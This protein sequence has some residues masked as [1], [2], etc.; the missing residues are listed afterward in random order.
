MIRSS[1]TPSV[2]LSVL[3]S[4]LLS[5]AGPVGAQGTPIG[6]EET[7]ALAPDRA[8]ALAELV[9]GSPEHF[10]YSCLH[11]QNSG[12]LESVDG[13]LR[14]WRERH[15]S[16]DP[17]QDRIELRQTLLRAS[18]DPQA[19]YRDLVRRLGLRFDQRPALADAVRDLPTRLDP[20]ELGDEVWL[21]DALAR[22]PGSLRGL[23]DGAL[24]RMAAR[25][26][27]GG[28]LRELL[29][30]LQ[31][32]DVPGLAR[33]V[34]R[35]LGLG[36]SRGFGAFPI[37]GRLL[38]AQLEECLSQRPELLADSN[39][40]R[41]Y[42]VRLAPGA[43]DDLR[44]PAVRL[45][46]LERL[47]RFAG[48]LPAAFDGLRAHVLHHRLD[49]DLDLDRLDAERLLAYLRV[50]RQPAYIDPVLRR[51][52][53]A[54]TLSEGWETGLPSIATDEPLVREY[55]GRL[56][57]RLDSFQRFVGVLR[58][59][60]V[61]R[62][63][64]EAKILSGA[65]DPERWFALLEDPRV[66]EELKQRVDL[67]L[68][69][70]LA[71]T[72]GP[73]QPVR[74]DV[75]VKN[76]ETLLVKVFEIDAA[77]FYLA[78]GTAPRLRELDA[79]LDLDGL[80]AHEER[81]YRY[82]ESPMR[83]VRRTFDFPALSEPGIYVVEWIGNGIASRAVIRKG[84]LRMTE[85]VGAAGHVLR[86]VDDRG[87]P[88]E[89]ASV[90]YAGR[91]YMPDER[92]EIAIPFSTDPGL[93]HLV[94]RR[95]NLAVLEEFEHLAEA[96]A[97]EAPA[98][99]EREALL[100]GER[101]TL[102]VRPRLQVA[103]RPISL[104]LLEGARLELRATDLD[105]VVAASTVRD[106]EL[107]NGVEFVHEFSVP[108]R[109]VSFSVQL[110]GRVR[111]LSE[112][113]DVELASNAVQVPLNGIDA[114]DERWTPLL[115][116]AAEGYWLEVRGKNGELGASRVVQVT[117]QHRDYTNART[118]QL[119]SDARGR[120]ELGS[121]EN[122][123]RLEVGGIGSQPSAWW[124][125]PPMPGGR[126]RELHALEG[127]AIR[128]PWD[129]AN[130]FSLFELRGGQYAFERSERGASWG[131][132]YLSLTD[133]AAGDYRLE[134]HGIGRVYDL[135]VT[136]GQRVSG[137]A[138]GAVRRLELSRPLELTIRDASVRG[139]ELVVQL[140]G[141]GPDARVHVSALRYVPDVDGHRRLSLDR[142]RNLAWGALHA[143]ENQYESG[144][145]ISDEYRY[146]L[147]RRFAQRFP[148]NLLA[149]AG[150]LLNPWAIDESTSDTSAG[151]GG[152]GG[153]FGGRRS[154]RSGGGVGAPA[155]DGAGAPSAR[156]GFANLDFLGEPALLFANLRPDEQGFVRLPL[157]RL[158]DRHLLQV[159]AVDGQATVSR[160]V[161]RPAVAPRLRDRRLA[162]SL[163]PRAHLVEDRRIEFLDAGASVTFTDATNAGVE[164]Y[165]DLGDVYRYFR[166]H[167]GSPELERFEFLV[168]WPALSQEEKL[169]RYSEFA[170]HELHVF[171][172]RKD[173]E[174]FERVVRPYLAHKAHKTFL[175]HWLL[176]ENLGGYLEPW[177]FAELNTFERILLLRE[178][179]GGPA[180]HVRELVELLPPE[181]FALR[182]YFDRLLA[183]R[184]LDADRT[185]LGVLL[186]E[187]ARAQE[188]AKVALVQVAPAPGAPPAAIAG[189]AR[190]ELGDAPLE[191]ALEEQAEL[192]KVLKDQ[193]YASNEEL[194]ADLE[195]R[196]AQEPFFQDL[197]DT[198]ELA[199]RHY[200]RVLLSA[201]D[202]GLVTPTPFW[203]D[204]AES[205][206]DGPF[207]S[208]RFPL[209]ARNLPEML[210]ALALLDLP[211]AAGEHT[212]EASPEG[213]VFTAGSRLFL[214]W[215]GMTRVEAAPDAR[216]I[217]VG[218]DFFR[219][220]DPFV[221]EQG[222]QRDKF[223]SG[224]FLVGVPYGCRVVV[225]NPTSTPVDVEVLLQIPAGA[226]PL[227]RGFVTRGRSVS[228]PGY[229]SASIEYGFY[230]PAAGTFR[231]Y[232]AHVGEDGALLA[233]AA[234]SE[235]Q[236]LAAPK[237]LDRT[238]WEHLSQAADL[239]TVLEHLEREN[240]ARLDLSRLAWRMRDRA[241]YGRILALLR[242]HMVFDPT[243]WSF[244]LHHGDPRTAR[245]FLERR[246]DLVAAAGPWLR[247]ELL[248]IEPVERRIYEHL[249][250]DPLVNARAHRFGPERRIYNDS[251]ARQYGRFLEVLAHKPAL[252]DLDRMALVH[253][254]LLQERI[255]EALEHFALIDPARIEARL[256]YDYLT[257]YLAFY[258]PEPGSARAIAAAHAEHPVPRW[259]A[260][261]GAVLAQLDEAEGR[262][263][264]GAGDPESRDERQGALA[265]AVPVLEL[266][267]EARRVTL[268]YANLGQAEIR[269]R[270]MN[271]E[272]LFSTSPFLQGGSGA[273]AAVQPHRVD[274]VELPK[275]RDTLV[276]D[277]PA[278]F[279]SANVL[280]EVRG[281]GLVRTQAYYAHDLRVEA[282]E[283]YGQLSVRRASDG[284][285]LPAT[286]VKVYAR[287]ADGR[288]RF[289]KDGYTDLRGRFDYVSVSGI[290]AAPSARFAV[291]VLSE[292]SGA[293]VR[294]LDPPRR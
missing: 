62:I 3:V 198:R 118:F 177:A 130:A 138:W 209:A 29:G 31:H 256:Q 287:L 179:E 257:A 63:F 133:L 59:D 220:D 234:P 248:T 24:P 111:S 98:H 154:L 168:R 25:D 285:P 144:R 190:Q 152:F 193:G 90:L 42:L 18:Q 123:S 254:L 136:R 52:Q 76:V 293:L 147:E 224:E 45:A 21:R 153:R 16:S 156:P 165:D 148:G 74:L 7:F 199:E 15:G 233:F 218:Q 37:H 277:L 126:P 106:L 8:R 212:S 172:R 134:L 100:A 201:M 188:H 4:L 175:D 122:I 73:G 71:R 265:A 278:E 163:D 161:L 239:E 135:R 132:S 99:V 129:G 104:A 191:D 35:E 185:Q 39:F 50:A 184:A 229:G 141:A 87:E 97:L 238:S 101:A 110:A 94:L 146:I 115:A 14:A 58:R 54:V 245:E 89:G 222:R 267:V 232:P 269:Y 65:P 292:E 112:S 67:R 109:S 178:L 30:R 210:L 271:I 243:L 263:P 282:R 166:T 20:A 13:L 173:P 6:F 164:V 57:E 215:R 93:R 205:A 56:F 171:L 9:P 121:L 78:Q 244:G 61:Q 275:D 279:A 125:A 167:G 91:E 81:T 253:Y 196:Q 288:I 294:E 26:L 158:G 2:R 82:E 44:D 107:R 70:G 281:G 272:L 12:E 155:R 223:V 36:G 186:E 151:E 235:L 105:G 200:W 17:R 260:R 174:F 159:V 182:T 170:G 214:A 250:Y 40:V 194:G 283:A 85:R 38:L 280:V 139:E 75:D 137:Q 84:T 251:F 127:E 162:V 289:H 95:G 114:T 290:D 47:E 228:L 221:F 262:T 131:E 208:S 204:F 113:K 217:L 103:G 53:P 213:V 51:D 255:G 145:R 92:G 259:R 19:S 160:S 273:F 86:V 242:R 240:L 237:E 197:A 116:R 41:A 192:D 49:L 5:F 140:A 207:V 119:Q 247:S 226:L 128:V 108:P 236:V 23:E 216:P 68:P 258:S 181:S 176:G 183:G 120:V 149:R 124:L 219:L 230:F 150:L 261:F 157:E 231:H 206:P 246:A 274:R 202:S 27:T 203:L 46:H 66:V 291:L 69:R 96:Y 80:V 10:F 286:Y 88:A 276:L 169:A 55:L 33:L 83:R 284:A 142:L 187:R 28:E 48:R 270:P 241:A 77:A 43:D 266:A 264:A 227:R 22:H 32:P 249:E 252:D 268:S 60:Y 211:F 1:T 72:F 225:T 102:V 79:T 117:L 189:R 143:P 180:R 64:A 34:V 195:R 11:A